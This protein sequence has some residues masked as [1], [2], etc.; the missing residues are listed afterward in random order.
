M[1]L[2]TIRKQGGLGKPINIMIAVDEMS[3]MIGYTMWM[4]FVLVVIDHDDPLIS[5]MGQTFCQ[6]WD[7]V[8]NA[9]P[10][11]TEPIFFCLG[12]PVFGNFWSGLQFFW[13]N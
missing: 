6:V 5:T 7:V 9:V 3:K 1:V 4:Q 2:H 12:Q 13:R 8:L 10:L 11:L